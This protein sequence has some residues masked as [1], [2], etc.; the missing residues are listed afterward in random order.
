MVK[1]KLDQ[2]SRLERFAV[3]KVVAF[4]LTAIVV[5]LLLME[6]V[7]RLWLGYA[8]HSMIE[9]TVAGRAVHTNAMLSVIRLC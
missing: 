1:K 3:G 4:S 6:G 5:P 7:S 2:D 9:A 8:P